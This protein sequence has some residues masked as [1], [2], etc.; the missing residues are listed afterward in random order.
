MTLFGVM[1]TVGTA[2]ALV[3]GLLMASTP[4]GVLLAMAG[5]LGLTA[6]LVSAALFAVNGL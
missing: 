4:V 5:G 3:V 2:A 6:Q 1:K